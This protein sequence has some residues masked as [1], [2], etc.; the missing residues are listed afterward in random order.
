MIWII[1]KHFVGHAIQGNP[2]S[3]EVDLAME[4]GIPRGSEISGKITFKSGQAEPKIFSQ[5]Q[6]SN[7]K[8]KKYQKNAKKTAIFI[9]NSEFLLNL[10]FLEIKN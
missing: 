4:K 5:N 10:I 7:E 6:K 3:R 8:I 1:Y 2:S 9:K